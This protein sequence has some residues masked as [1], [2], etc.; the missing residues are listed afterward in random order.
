MVTAVRDIAGATTLGP[1]D[2]TTIEITP[3]ALPAG[4]LT[5]TSDV[6]GQRAAGPI[7]AGEVITDVRLVGS[8]LL[9]GW[10][11]DLAAVPVRIADPGA[12]QLVR[13]GDVID[14]VATDMSGAVSA[15]VLAAQVP[16]LAVPEDAK[17]SF[18]ADGAL[19]VVAATPDQIRG[20]ANAAVTSRLS[21]ALR[22]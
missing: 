14:I 13:P 9:D 10:G 20:L 18:A 19:L 2:V 16:V 6:H 17:T 22:H 1:N 8:A 7:R 15:S 21:I 12:A 3:D 11:A 5:T 4:A